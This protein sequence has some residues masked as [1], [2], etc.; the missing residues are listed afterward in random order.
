MLH[1]NLMVITNQ[2]SIL[3]KHTH[4]QKRERNPNVTQ[5]IVIK[6]RNKKLQT[7]PENNE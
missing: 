4:T 6:R 2:K 3:D 5:K 7:Q 1:M